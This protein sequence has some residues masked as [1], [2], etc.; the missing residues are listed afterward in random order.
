MKQFIITIALL[1]MPISA[2]Y[3]HAQENEHAKAMHT[4]LWETINRMLPKNISS[5]WIPGSED[6]LSWFIDTPDGGGLVPKNKT[7]EV[8]L[9]KNKVENFL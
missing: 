9:G 4:A 8:K 6:D 3:L 5:K 7:H 1:L 2:T